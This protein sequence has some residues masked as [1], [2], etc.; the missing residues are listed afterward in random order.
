MELIDFIFESVGLSMENNMN[1]SVVHLKRHIQKQ[2]VKGTSARGRVE[3][4]HYS[5][6]DSVIDERTRMIL[7]K[8][9]NS[10]RLDAVGGVCKVGKEAAVVLGVGWHPDVHAELVEENGGAQRAIAWTDEDEDEEE[11]EEED[12]TDNP[13]ADAGDPPRAHADAADV[14]VVEEEEEE[15]ST[16]VDEETEDVAIKIF[17][18]SLNEFK[19]RRDYMDGDRRYSKTKLKHQNPRKIVTLWAEKEFKNLVRVHRAGI[20]SPAPY[21]LRGHVIVMNFL[22]KDGWPAPQLKEAPISSMREW[23]RVYRQTVAIMVAMYQWTHLVHADLS[24]YNLL[25][26]DRRVHVVDL[27][28]AVDTSHPQ[29][30]EFLHS[31]CKN[32]TRFFERKGVYVLP[33]DEL[34]NLIKSGSVG[35]QPAAG[36]RTGAAHGHVPAVGSG[37]RVA[38]RMAEEARIASDAVSGYVNPVESATLAGER[39]ADDHD[40]NPEV[41]ECDYFDGEENPIAQRIDELLDA[42]AAR[43]KATTT[44][45]P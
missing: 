36:V 13:G 8:L 25:Y 30:D 20:P 43:D 14:D 3:E 31:D 32:V 38:Q 9:I 19:D 22:G 34:F 24:E 2:M 10:G 44:T 28:Q 18:L 37:L 1:A 17:K 11:D 41:A 23:S 29:S 6:Q 45:S 27:G 42:L 39:A 5:T 16:A 40:E 33:E 35:A 12:A 15:E 21:I 7:V 4:S 26:W